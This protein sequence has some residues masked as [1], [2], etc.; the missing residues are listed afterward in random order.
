M[1]TVDAISMVVVVVAPGRR[2]ISQPS[3]DIVRIRSDV[4]EEREEQGEGPGE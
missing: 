3:N 1:D 2:P 4:E